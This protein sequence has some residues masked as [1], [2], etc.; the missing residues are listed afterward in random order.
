MYFI[1]I[2]MDY[3]FFL[4]F[5]I[6]FSQFSNSQEKCSQFYSDFNESVIIGEL[7][8]KKELDE[9]YLFKIQEENDQ[10]RNLKIF[11]NRIGEELFG[12]LEVDNIIRKNKDNM[13]LIIIKKKSHNEP[14]NIRVFPQLC[15][16]GNK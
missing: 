11:K 2:K 16:N 6:F 9:F 10:M 14:S 7:K 4:G 12:Y 1:I 15:D 13:A 5:F 3:K 8:E